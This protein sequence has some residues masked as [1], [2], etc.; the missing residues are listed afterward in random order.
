M[1]SVVFQVIARSTTYKKLLLTIKGEY[2]DVIRE[3]QRR[4]GE[5]RMVR[6]NLEASTSH[7]R[8]L[9]TC[10]RRAAELRERCVCVCD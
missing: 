2:D 3:L 5:A 4:E 1:I 8:S 7:P 9:I 10:Q 6:R